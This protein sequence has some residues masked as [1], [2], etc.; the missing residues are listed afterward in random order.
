MN[1]H[2]NR[3]E[4]EK[5]ELAQNI[6]EFMNSLMKLDEN[7]IRALVEVRVSLDKDT[8]HYLVETRVCC[9]KEFA[10]H[11]TVQVSTPANS[12]IPSVGLLGILNGF[13]GVDDQQWGYIAA[14]YGDDGRL[15][16]FDLRNKFKIKPE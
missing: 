8:A 2:L 4:E 9:S 3:T 5:I 6:C 11:P 14:I 12:K 1:N 15:T 13:V 10:D 7:T 16:G